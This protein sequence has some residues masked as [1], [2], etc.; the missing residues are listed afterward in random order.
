MQGVS[1]LQVMSKRKSYKIDRIVREMHAMSSLGLYAR[2]PTAHSL[3]G[4]PLKLWRTEWAV[5]THDMHSFCKRKAQN[6]TKN[7]FPI[8]SNQFCDCSF[9]IFPPI[10]SPCTCPSE[11]ILTKKG[12]NRKKNTSKQAF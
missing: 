1:K 2:V 11:T 9:L 10:Y 7:E 5:G 12:I 8:Q 3:R 6:L 4:N